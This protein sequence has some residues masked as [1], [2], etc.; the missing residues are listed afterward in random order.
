MS[1]KS[2]LFLRIKALFFTGAITA[3]TLRGCTYGPPPAVVEPPQDNQNTITQNSE[4]PSYNILLSIYDE[5][6]QPEEK[7]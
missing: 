4:V 3:A 1:D 2:K 5:I 6:P 7:L